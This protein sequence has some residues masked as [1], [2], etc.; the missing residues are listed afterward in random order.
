M[1]TYV[2][3]VSFLISIFTNLI[4]IIQNIDIP[5]CSVS[6]TALALYKCS[7]FWNSSALP[8]AR[9]EYNLKRSV[10]H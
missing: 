4:N 8:L 5:I 2:K 1:S 6:W 3:Y 10:D 7:P 9:H